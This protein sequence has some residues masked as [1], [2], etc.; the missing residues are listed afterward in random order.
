MGYLRE[1]IEDGNN[2]QKALNLATGTA[3]ENLAWI[4]KL[5]LLYVSTKEYKVMDSSLKFKLS[6]VS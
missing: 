5:L 6:Y 1:A 3:P 4:H 2:L